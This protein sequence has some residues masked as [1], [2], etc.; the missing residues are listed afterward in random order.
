MQ[1]D[2]SINIPTLLA[3]GSVLIGLIRIHA[4]YIRLEFKVDELW[5]SRNHSQHRNQD[6]DDN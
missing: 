1:F 3:L 2:S 5:K 4:S 6:R